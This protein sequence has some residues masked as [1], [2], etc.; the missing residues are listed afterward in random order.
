MV[1]YKLQYYHYRP[2]Q[3]FR[4]AFR[5]QQQLITDIYIFILNLHTFKKTLRFFI[6]YLWL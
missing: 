2:E 6:N 5:L 1:H 3:L 4:V